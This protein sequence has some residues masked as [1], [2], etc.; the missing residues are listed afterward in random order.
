M[1]ADGRRRGARPRVWHAFRTDRVAEA[2]AT[3]RT[4]EVTDLP[5]AARLVADTI[6]RTG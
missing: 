2:H 3:G 5:D 6:T 4:A 1:S